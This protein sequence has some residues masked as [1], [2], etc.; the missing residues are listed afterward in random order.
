MLAGGVAAGRSDPAPLSRAPIE[1]G[2]IN[3]L[4][5][6][7][8]HGQWRRRPAAFPGRSGSHVPARAPA[9]VSCSLPG[10][11]SKNRRVPRPPELIMEHLATGSEPAE[12]CE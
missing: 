2:V 3:A 8:P 12:L 1:P 11:C 5:G 9:P 4:S 7:G 6:R 10:R